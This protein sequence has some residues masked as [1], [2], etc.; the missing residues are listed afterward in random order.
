MKLVAGALA[1]LAIPVLAIAVS[2]SVLGGV[3]IAAGELVF[4]ASV[5]QF[6]KSRH[7]HE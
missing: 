1:F 5:R 2:G 4:G 7:Q 6:R 3:L